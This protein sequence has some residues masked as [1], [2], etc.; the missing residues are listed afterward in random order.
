MVLPSME[1]QREESEL[2][3]EDALEPVAVPKLPGSTTVREALSSAAENGIVLV[4]CS[5]G[6]WYTARCEEMD[7]V[8]GDLTLEQ[9]AGRERVPVLF[10]DLPL[11]SSLSHFDRWPL[12]PVTHRAIGGS[13]VGTVT[14]Q[15][16]LRRFQRHS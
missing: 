2:R 11:S 3:L 14:L 10:P 1:E 13:V 7:T 16:V 4:H 15:G 5:D 6:G 12:L 9:L 8:S